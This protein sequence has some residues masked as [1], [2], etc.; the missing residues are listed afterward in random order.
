MIV[1]L[2]NDEIDREQW[3]N[4]IKNSSVTRPYAYSWYLD[5]MAPGWEGAG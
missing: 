1:Y 2:K 3:D 5:I 4:C